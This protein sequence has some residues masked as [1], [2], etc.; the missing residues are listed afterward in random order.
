MYSRRYQTEAQQ[1][2][3]MESLRKGGVDGVYKDHGLLYI[4]PSAKV[5]DEP[6]IDALTRKM[7][8][9]FR[10]A[11][12]DTAFGFAGVHTCACGAQSDCTDVVLPNG[13]VTNTLCVHYLACHR[14]E[15]PASELEKVAQL[16]SGEAEPSPDEIYH[17]QS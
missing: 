4:V 15:V 17:P 11:D 14:D 8:A 3:V 1:E 12:D 2:A 16:D 9:A 7:T 13:T 10:A 6:T 5:S